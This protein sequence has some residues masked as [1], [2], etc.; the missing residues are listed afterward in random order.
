MASVIIKIKLQ[1]LLLA[2]ALIITMSC[3][4]KESSESK[5]AKGS[6]ETFKIGITLPFSGELAAYG[7]STMKGIEMQADEINA[8]GGIN[9]RK[10]ELIQ[11]NNEG[12]TTKSSEGLRKLIGLNKVAAVIGPITSRNTMAIARDAQRKKSGPHNANCD[13]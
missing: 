9:G 5:G 12:D 4:N 3:G 13:K 10:L 11:E 2:L 7:K 6:A 1:N 8:A